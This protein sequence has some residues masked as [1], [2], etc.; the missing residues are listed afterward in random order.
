MNKDQNFTE[1]WKSNPVTEVKPDCDEL[2]PHFVSV[3]YRDEEQ[4][5]KN[6]NGLKQ[7]TI[8]LI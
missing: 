2:K 3:S 4:K 7:I 6:K 1:T 8:T 5:F